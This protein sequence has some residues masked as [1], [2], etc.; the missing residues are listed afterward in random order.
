MGF[1]NLLGPVSRVCRGT[2]L[3]SWTSFEMK[4]DRK[5]NAGCRRSLKSIN[6]SSLSTSTGRHLGSSIS[7]DDLARESRQSSSAKI[8]SRT[9]QNDKYGTWTPS[10][11]FLPNCFQPDIPVLV[12]FLQQLSVEALECNLP[13]FSRFLHLPDQRLSLACHI[14]VLRLNHVK[15]RRDPIIKDATL[16][17][18]HLSWSSLPEP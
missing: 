2:V 9:T 15:F 13:C 1:A 10:K 6:A 5:H 8:L 16:P 14:F 11:R 12:E 4:S 3:P 7:A 17:L 18:F